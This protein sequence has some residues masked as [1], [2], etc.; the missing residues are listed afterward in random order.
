M[1]NILAGK[2]TFNTA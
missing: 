1:I 2:K